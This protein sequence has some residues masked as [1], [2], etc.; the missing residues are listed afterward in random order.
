MARPR[1]DEEYIAPKRPPATTVAARENQLIALAV[2]LAE[3]QL[4]DGTASSQVQTHFLRLATVREEIERDKLRSENALLKA[5]VDALASSQQSEELYQRA[6]EAM[7]SYKPSDDI[8]EE[9]Q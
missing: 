7:T 1:K 4:R 9:F 6:I 3:R 2:D 8:P 5:R